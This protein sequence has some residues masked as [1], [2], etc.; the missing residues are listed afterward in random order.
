MI[1][2]ILH[3]KHAPISETF[4]LSTRNLLDKLLQKDPLDRPDIQHIL[5]NPD[6][7]KHVTFHSRIS[8]SFSWL[9]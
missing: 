7:I 5:S 4:S 2:K 6:I 9:N 3:E 1:Y 8:Q